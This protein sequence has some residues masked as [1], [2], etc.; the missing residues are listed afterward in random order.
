M[1]VILIP[2]FWLDASSWERV[3]P[4]L[5]ET[6]HRLH[7]VT[8][9]GLESAGADRTGIGLADHIAA[10][11]EL[12]DRLEGPVVLVG[13]SGGGSVAHGVV[14]A[15]PERIAKV[16]YVDAGPPAPGEVIN[17]QLPVV[18]GEVPLPDWSVFQDEDLVDLDDALRAEF[19]ARAITEPWGVA[20][21][22]IELTDPRRYEVPI[23]IIACEFPSVVLREAVDAG[24]PWVRELA[25]VAHVEYVDLPTGHW[26]QFTKPVQLGQAI[27][28]VLPSS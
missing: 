3:T 27:A 20:S 24:Q 25:K 2:G 8:L 17:D 7:P 12:V 1:D 10:V 15:R 16:V 6:G 22:P 21:D 11:T 28:S 4:V 9:P 5:A 18:D 13:H 23:A 19:R 14:D 26:P